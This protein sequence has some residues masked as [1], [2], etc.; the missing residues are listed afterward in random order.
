MRQHPQWASH[1]LDRRPF[2]WD[3]NKREITVQTLGQQ[4]KDRR[5][6]ISV[7]RAAPRK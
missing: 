4:P 3:E 6:G 1:P 7:W 5:F 2:V